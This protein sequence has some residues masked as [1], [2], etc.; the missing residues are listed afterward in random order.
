MTTKAQPSYY[1]VIPADVRYA[2]I[3]ANAKLLYGEIT[4]L[5]HKEGYC[6]AT[7]SYFAGLYQVDNY[8]ITRWVSALIK[9]EFISIEVDQKKG[10]ERKITLANLPTKLR[11]P[12]HKNVAT[13]PQKGAALPIENNTSTITTTKESTPATK[14][15]EFFTDPE[16][17]IKMLSEKFP[18]AVVR[19]EVM[20][21]ISYWTE[22]SRTGKMRYEKEKFFEINRR[23]ATWFSR[24][25]E[26]AKE[27]KG[28][29]I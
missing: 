2:D 16:P 6:W 15:N 14:A 8:T 12:T 18:E 22:P 20:K 19:R 10:N 1:A 9:G 4:A 11:V 5:C 21:F 28:I 25:R 27:T 29:V 13:Y 17:I 24:A 3:P 26:Y 23:L 7:N